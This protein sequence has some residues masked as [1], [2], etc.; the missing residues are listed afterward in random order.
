MPEKFRKYFD[1]IP[2]LILL[3]SAVMLL[4]TVFT[5]EIVLIWKHYLGLILL[6]VTIFL[7]FVKHKLGVLCLGLVLLMGLIGLLSYSPAI[8]DFSVSHTGFGT[9][10]TLVRFQPIFL[11]WLLIHFILSYRS[12]VGVLTKKYWQNL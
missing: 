5:G 9:S 10:I 2:L 3:I 12:Y 11:L 6:L 1:Y 7:F 8:A 4:W